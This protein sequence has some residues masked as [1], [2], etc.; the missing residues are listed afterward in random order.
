M[1]KRPY[2]PMYPSDYLADTAFLSLEAHGMYFLLLQNLWLHDGELPAD[3]KKLARLMRLDPRQVRRYLGH[4]VGGKSE[5]E[6]SDYFE[7]SN[8]L[9]SNSRLSEELAKCIDKSEKNR[10]AALTRHHANAEQTH[11]VKHAIPE[12]D[13]NTDKKKNIKKKDLTLPKKFTEWWSLYPKKR[14]KVEAL[15]IWNRDNLESRADEIIAAT[16]QQK[17]HERAWREGYIPDPTTY[18]NNERWNDEIDRT[19]SRQPGSAKPSGIERGDA[20]IVEWLAEESGGVLG[21][22]EPD[23]SGSV[24]INM[25][26]ETV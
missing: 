22:D 12:P 26:G 5:G 2:Y 21:N 10:K 23:V 16:E 15:K 7:V 18:L 11:H 3:A 20:A 6:L 1:P 9:L 19:D 25:R 14:K 8:G 24:V 4:K 17:A 13:S